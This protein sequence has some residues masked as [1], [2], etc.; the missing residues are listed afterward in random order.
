MRKRSALRWIN[1][2]IGREK[3]YIILMLSVQILIGASSVLYAYLFRDIIDSAANKEPERFEISVAFIYLIAVLQIILRTFNRWLEEKA[4]ST[5]ENKFQHRLFDILLKKNYVEVSS[6]HSAAWSNRLTSD[7]VIV[8]DGMAQ[9]IPNVTGMGVKMIGAVLMILYLEPK[10]ALLLIPRGIIFLVLTYSFRKILKRLHKNVQEKDSRLRI[11]IQEHMSDLMIVRAF[12][13]ERSSLKKA[14]E[15]MPDHQAARME[16]NHFS[17]VC[18]IVFSAIMNGA[19]IIGVIWCGYGILHDT[20]SYGTLMAILQLISQIQ[21]L[22]ANIT[23]YL[24]KY[25]AMLASAERL[26]EAEE[27]ADISNSES[28]TL[29]EV[30]KFYSSEFKSIEMK[31]VC[32]SYSPSGVDEGKTYEKE[33]SMR[34]L[35]NINLT[36]N[37]GEYIALM[38]CSGCGKSTL[39]KVLMGIY[40]PDSGMRVINQNIPLTYDWRR[41]FS[42]VPQGNALMSGTIRETIA[43]ADERFQKDD[44]GMNEDLKIACADK[45][46]S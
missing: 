38:G 42:Y 27:F 36:I 45:F 25:Y 2:V 17:N 21:T 5:Y 20:V 16:R 43:F 13:A 22:F 37:K 14:D 8:A 18:N 1:K 31:N 33:E 28:R 39:L 19:Y 4:R 34:V 12:G 29:S 40:D 10:L 24:P 9:I 26:M 23:G 15:K 44:M 30:M 3:S 32:F 6:V 7:T 35:D 11:F 41:L 46:V